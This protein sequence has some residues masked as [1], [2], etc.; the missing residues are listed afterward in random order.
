V[1]TIVSPA[2]AQ[3]GCDNSTVVAHLEWCARDHGYNEGAICGAEALGGKGATAA[4]GQKVLGNTWDRTNMMYAARQAAREGDKDQAV[5]AAI[6]C[7]IHN[8]EAMACLSGNRPAVQ[9]WLLKQ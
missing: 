6:C 8:R 9:A 7:Q 5:R 2:I 1:L 4:L 3:A